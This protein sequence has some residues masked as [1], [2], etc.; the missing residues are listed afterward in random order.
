MAL[1]QDGKLDIYLAGWVFPF[2]AD[3]DLWPDREADG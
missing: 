3:P 2:H 1:E